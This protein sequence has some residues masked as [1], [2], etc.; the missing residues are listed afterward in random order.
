MICFMSGTLLK[1][2]PCCKFML[3]HDIKSYFRQFTHLLPV[4]YNTHRL[5]NVQPWNYNTY[6]SSMVQLC[7]A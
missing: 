3:N 7:L 4:K 1:E 6:Y 2:E 5:G